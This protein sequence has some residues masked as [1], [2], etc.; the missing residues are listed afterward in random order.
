MILFSFSPLLRKYVCVCVALVQQ[1]LKMA[2]K[3][4]R[5][6]PE[7]TH[8]LN[9]AVRFCCSAAAVALWLL[10]QPPPATALQWEWCVS[11][12]AAAANGKHLCVCVCGVYYAGRSLQCMRAG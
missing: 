9:I 1:S 10:Q 12:P 5:A 2:H 3:F 6:A 4:E 8:F 11:A 7:L